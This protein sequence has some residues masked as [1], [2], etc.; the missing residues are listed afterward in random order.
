MINKLGLTEGNNLAQESVESLVTH[1]I[2]PKRDC[3]S[4]VYDSAIEKKDILV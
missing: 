3:I 2:F 4:R 1:R